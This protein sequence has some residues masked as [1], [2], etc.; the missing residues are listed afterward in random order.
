VVSGFAAELSRRW[1]ERPARQV[2]AGRDEVAAN[3][4]A[5]LA[6]MPVRLATRR[7]TQA[8]LQTEHIAR[9]LRDAGARVELVLIDT[10]GDRMRDRPLAEIGGRG[11]FTKEIQQAVLDGSADVAVHSAKDL[12][13]SWATPGLML[14][15]FT[16]RGDPRDALVG[17]SL[18][19]L[20]TGATVAT[21]SARRQ[22]Q[23]ANLR[24]DLRF[25]GLRGNIGTRVA[26]A[27]D[28]DVDAVV[29]AMTGVIWVGE[30]AAVSEALD[31]DVMIPQV[32]QGAMALECR[33]DDEVAMAL[34]S[35]LDHNVTRRC[36]ES[37]RAF[38]S[39]LG[40][41]CDLPVGAHATLSGERVTIRG[42][43]GALDGSE[44]FVDALEGVGSEV[45]A[46][47]A[48]RM[49]GRAAHLLPR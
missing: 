13:S 40:G 39:V 12:P 22:S 32:G 11:V 8:R 30:R 9:L 7:S 31:V 41:G 14:A 42:F 16:E 44:V 20:P 19:D 36:V 5:T 49:L 24:P 29:V 47:L 38:L 3:D 37:E 28:H 46:T 35:V 4:P 15:A 21:G 33:D 6:A 10:A 26:R 27:R 18:V 43:I 23:L 45:G 25:V 2:A 34:L 48:D 1:A 17:S